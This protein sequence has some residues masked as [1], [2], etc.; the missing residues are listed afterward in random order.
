MSLHTKALA[1]SGSPAFVGAEPACRQAGL[2]P[3]AFIRTPP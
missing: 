1:R 3:P 2:P